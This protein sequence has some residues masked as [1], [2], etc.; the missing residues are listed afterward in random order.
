MVT[1]NDG[2][3]QSRTK[4]DKDGE[5]AQAQAANEMDDGEHQCDA[6]D[7]LVVVTVPWRLHIG[8][9]GRLNCNHT[10]N[11]GLNVG[12]EQGRHR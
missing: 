12:G 4:K 10:G 5:V 8:G 11:L 2:T 9:F 7:S 3:D 1:H 6:R